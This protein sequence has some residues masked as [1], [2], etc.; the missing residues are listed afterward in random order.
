MDPEQLRSAVS[1]MTMS[2]WTK[3]FHAKAQS[4]IKTPR[5]QRA[6]AFAA[7]LSSWRLGVKY[8]DFDFFVFPGR[9]IF[10]PGPGSINTKFSGWA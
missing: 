8:S 9:R 7:F 3:I 5:D 10:A 6:I 4:R 1:G 2:I